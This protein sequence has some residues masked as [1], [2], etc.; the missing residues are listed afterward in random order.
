[1]P[2]ATATATRP[3]P[4]ARRVGLDTVVNVS[5]LKFKTSGA[6]GAGLVAVAVA[7][8]VAAGG[9]LYSHAG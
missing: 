8:A 4:K 6:F 9:I 7:V 3:A 1:M 2:P 5:S